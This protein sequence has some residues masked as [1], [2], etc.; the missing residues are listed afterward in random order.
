V[1]SGDEIL[2]VN[3][4]PIFF[5][6]GRFP[7][8]RDLGPGLMGPDVSQL[9]RA[10]DVPATGVFDDITQLAV[11]KLFMK[12]GHK[13]AEQLLLWQLAVAPDVGV[14]TS[15]PAFGAVLDASSKLVVSSGKLVLRAEMSGAVAGE[16]NTGQ[17]AELNLGEG[18]S[19]AATIVRISRPQTEDSNAVVLIAPDTPLPAS[20]IGHEAVAVVV[21]N[22]VAQDELIVPSASI[23]NAG[24]ST[25]YVIKR[26]GATFTEI[27][28]TELASQDGKSAVR[29]EDGSLHEG[30]EVQVGTG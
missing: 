20:S 6:V 29:V 2:E 25:A 15:A 28:V 14:L 30:D 10:L 19:V 27:P 1:R 13:E 18:E 24:D 22:R 23:V 8:Y 9:Q 26:E 3:G 5:F 4:E 12:A 21:V 16:L 7:F 17:D 11:R